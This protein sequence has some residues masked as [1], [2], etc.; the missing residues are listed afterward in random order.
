MLSYTNSAPV[1]A[2]ISMVLASILVV[3]LAGLVLLEVITD[4]KEGGQWLDDVKT[5]MAWMNLEIRP[6]SALTTME[7][8]ET[9]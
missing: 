6:L 7:G 2:A 8:L 5:E 4:E 9:G 3:D 1:I